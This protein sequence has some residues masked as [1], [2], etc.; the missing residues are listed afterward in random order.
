MTPS[1]LFHGRRLTRLMRS[2]RQP[3]SDSRFELRHPGGLPRGRRK[4]SCALAPAS[5][6]IQSIHGHIPGGLVPASLP[7][8]PRSSPLRPQIPDITFAYSFQSA[9]ELASV[10]ACY[11]LEVLAAGMLPRSPHGRVYGVLKR[12][13]RD[14]A[15]HVPIHSNFSAI[16]ALRSFE[17]LCHTYTVNSERENHADS[18]RLH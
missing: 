5:R 16:T 8:T 9:L 18:S 7:A 12:V 4:P 6:S 14:D 15:S 11:P 1:P 17:L 13:I 3:G 2:E 10:V